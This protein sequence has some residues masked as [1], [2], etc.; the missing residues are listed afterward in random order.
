MKVIFIKDLKGQGKKNEIKDVKDGY[1]TNFLI[2]NG[3]A[4]KATDNSLSKLKKQNEE[5]A[6]QENLLIKQMQELKKKLEKETLVFKVKTGSQDKMFGSISAK[7]I[8][9]NM[10]SLGYNIDKN[11]IK[12]N[13]PITSLGFHQIEVLLHKKVIAN[14]KIKVER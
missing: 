12:I 14:V 3:Y 10:E 9:S 4:V 11:N 2:K 1:A 5:E 7:Q 13:T 8:K 6:L